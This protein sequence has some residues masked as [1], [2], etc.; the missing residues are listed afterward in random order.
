V[1]TFGTFGWPP[2]DLATCH[3]SSRQLSP[4]HPGGE[5]LEDLENESL[6]GLVVL[7]P[8]GTIERRY[9]LAQ[10]LRALKIGA[11][12]TALAPKDKGGS[13]LAKEL[14]ELGCEFEEEAKRHHRICRGIRPRGGLALE[15]A[16]AEG[17][18]RF[19]ETLGM[20]T[21]PGVFSWNRIDP[22]SAFLVEHL[23]KLSGRGA[24]FGSGIG[25]LSRHLLREK[26]VKHLTLV[27][28]DSRAVE[29]AGKN[30]PERTTIL[31]RDLR[32]GEPVARNLDFVVTNPPFHDGGA[33]DRELGARFLVRAAEAL[34]KGGEA[35][36]VANQ[37]LPYEALL[38]SAFTSVKLVAENGGYKIFRAT[39]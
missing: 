15:S 34:K 9:T 29:C 8:P 39:T 6:A 14:R 23:P 27:E 33:E 35:W 1:N 20:F 37:H 4:L 36:I 30:V 5:R 19:D 28:I 31:W 17:K 18:L 22:G 7:A 12:F 24:D 10:G 2:R 32:E 16:L 11:E 21:Q 38:A 25:F 3:T 13:R 26:E